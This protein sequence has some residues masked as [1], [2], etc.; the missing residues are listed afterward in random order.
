MNERQLAGLLRV[1]QGARAPDVV[2]GVVQLVAPRLGAF[3]GRVGLLA[4]VG[5]PGTG[6][7]VVGSVAGSRDTTS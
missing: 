7:P 4:A 3:A 2:L 5:L 6:M 1:G